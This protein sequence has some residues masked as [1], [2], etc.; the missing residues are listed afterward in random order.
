[1]LVDAIIAKSEP[2]CSMNTDTL[3]YVQGTIE[4]TKNIEMK[5]QRS[6]G[7]TLCSVT[8]D[9]KVNGKWHKTK[10]SYGYGPDISE[11]TGCSR[12]I[13]NAKVILLRQVAPEK[14][15]NQQRLECTDAKINHGFPGGRKLLDD[16]QIL[17]WIEPEFYTK[18]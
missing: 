1:M 17:P 9:A 18:R 11:N 12:A 7:T 6:S 10:G 14:L 8:L 15:E 4:Q 3:A 16:T 5:H 13:Q 2:Y